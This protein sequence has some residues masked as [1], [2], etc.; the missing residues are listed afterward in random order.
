[1]RAAPSSAGSIWSSGI[2]SRARSRRAASFPRKP[3]CICPILRSPIPRTANRPASVSSSWRR[4]RISARCGWPRGRELRSMAETQG[5]GKSDKGAA[6]DKPARPPKGDKPQQAQ[7]GSKPEPAE[8][9]A[10]GEAVRPKARKPEERVTPR[11]KTHFEEVVGKKLAD[12]FGYKNRMQG[13]LD[14]KMVLN[15]SI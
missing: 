7:K 12:Q 2:R 1:M 8:A 15:M 11:L 5:K 10:K 14:Q 3:R 4:A 9:A 6:A 13:P